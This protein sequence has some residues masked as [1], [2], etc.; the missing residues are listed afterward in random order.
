MLCATTHGFVW[1]NIRITGLNYQNSVSAVQTFSLAKIQLRSSELARL[2][3]MD[4]LCT[5]NSVNET[6]KGVMFCINYGD[7]Y[8][9]QRYVQQPDTR[10]RY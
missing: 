8:D 7:N 3:S 2:R 6:R 1:I 9:I 4:S 10:V 5:C